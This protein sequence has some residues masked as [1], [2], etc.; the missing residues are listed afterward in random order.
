MKKIIFLFIIL[1]SICSISNAQSADELFSAA[2]NI[3]IKKGEQSKDYLDA[4]SVAIQQASN[5]GDITRAYINRKKHSDIVLKKYGENS[6]EYA[7]DLVRLANTSLRLGDTI[8]SLDKYTQASSIFEK[9]LKINKQHDQYIQ[10]YIFALSA[11]IEYSCYSNHVDDVNEYSIKL[12]KISEKYNGKNSCNHFSWLYFISIANKTIGLDNNVEKYTTEI[13]DN[14]I[15]IDSCNYQYVDAA[16]SF[17]KSYYYYNNQYDEQIK[18]AINHINKLELSHQPMIKELVDA[19]AYLLYSYL[20]DL[21]IAYEYGK[22]A[23]DLLEKNIVSVDAY[24]YFNIYYGMALNRDMIGDYPESVHYYGLCKKIYQNSGLEN[25]KEY[26]GILNSLFNCASRAGDYD[27]VVSLATEIEPLISTYSET[28]LEDY[29]DYLTKVYNASIKLGQHALALKL[30]DDIIDVVEQLHN[31]EE[32]LFDKAD[33]LLGKA[34][35]YYAMGQKEDAIAY[36]NNGYSIINLLPKDEKTILVLKARYLSLEG[37]MSTN[38]DEAVSKYNSALFLCNS[39]SDF[40]I[41]T[42]SL[43]DISD[44]SIISNEQ[45]SEDKIYAIQLINWIHGVEG[46]IL[47]N[48]GLTLMNN[49]YTERAL[50]TFLEYSTIIEKLKP[51]NSIEYITSQN[52]IA[53]CQMYLGYYSDAINTLDNALNIV[54]DNYGEKNQYYAYIMLN[55]SLYYNILGDYNK[56]IECSKEAARISKDYGTLDV[57]MNALSNM[58]TGYL[59]LYSYEEAEFY[60]TEAS[61][62]MESTNV[63]PI[64]LH[65]VYH[66]LAM[67][68]YETNRVPDGDMYFDKAKKIIIDTYGKLSVEYAELTGGLGWELFVKNNPKAFDEMRTAA[69]IMIQLGYVHHPTYIRA[70]SQYGLMGVVFNK[71]LVPN[72]PSLTLNAL[73]EYYNINVGYFTSSDRIFI[74]NITTFIKNVNHTTRINAQN[75]VCL[76]DLCLFS[77]ALMLATINNFKKSVYNTHNEELIRQYSDIQT[78]K[79][80]IDN[81]NF[82]QST[83]IQSSELYNLMTSLERSLIAQLKEIGAYTA[84]VNIGYAYVV[85]HLKKNEI[86]I[87]FVDYYNIK[88]EQTYYIAMLVKSSWDK[89]VYV[90]LCKDIDLN[91]CIGN[92]N[93]MYSTDELYQLLW[94]PLLKYI[95][96]GDVVYFSP[97]G[98]LHTISIEALHTPDGSYLKDNYNLIRLTSTRELCVSRPTKAY[99]SSV[100]YGGLNYDVEQH[101]MKEIAQQYG[102]VSGDNIL[103]SLRGD[104][105]GNWNYL[106]GTKEEASQI[107]VIMQKSKIKYDVFESDFGN[108]ESFKSLSDKDIDIIHLATHG[109]FIKSDMTDK[110]LFMN[111]LSNNNDSIIDPML[112]SGLILSGGNNAW[113][114]NAT[115]SDIEDGVLTALEISNMNLSN[116]DLVVL[117]ACETG[118]GEITNDGVFGLQRAFKMAGVQT[119]V[120]SLWK[121]D[122]M[123]TSLMM[124]TFYEQLLSG[125]S[126][127]DAFNI[128]QNT[129][130]NKYPEPYYW[131]AF[132]MLD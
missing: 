54:L 50:N 39:Y 35:L 75:D 123:A 43:S 38:V 48:K 41:D 109:F 34:Q 132:I 108:E 18:T 47:L 118:L 106:P 8:N 30:C 92:P 44:K 86:A 25:T 129:V 111:N 66:N 6:L 130:R 89:P 110:N 32:L 62:L 115:S 37:L 9:K 76:Y 116:T 14:C 24:S 49:G 122:D 13:I 119:L 70:L 2:E 97:S 57:Y 124:Q 27:L 64:N 20:S 36:I 4:L 69:E 3:K 80:Q 56:L 114:G 55:M 28:V 15:E 91:N 42:Y 87:E 82:S 103:L 45:I 60:L 81:L 17:L 96:K 26:Y 73:R 29:Y 90:P 22:K 68:S 12:D 52:D 51:K 126:K 102:T 53:L 74:T 112:R 101:R 61:S 77:K 1:F 71:P 33:V 105:R 98:K 94:Q 128:A 104:N 23:E 107:A 78:L 85:Q 5:E 72:Y 63:P 10:T 21:N 59:M 120:M 83:D 99:H 16:Y 65:K 121:V 58:G 79:T 88:E 95:N 84:D 100:I 125:K 127:R 93:V 131:A 11:I 31:G 117:S 7:D 113:L 46:E 19:N 67:L 40:I